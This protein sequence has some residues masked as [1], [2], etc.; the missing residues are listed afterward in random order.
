MPNLYGIIGEHPPN[1]CSISNKTVREAARKTLGVLPSL[2]QK[3]NVKLIGQYHFDPKHL[4]VMILEA[5]NV[6]SVRDVIEQSGFTQWVNLEI[7]PATPIDKWISKA[8][9]LPTIF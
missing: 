8:E 7:Y 5:D 1:V 3:H 6:E 9:Q 4:G 2:L